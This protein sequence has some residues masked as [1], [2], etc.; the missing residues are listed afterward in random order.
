MRFYSPQVT[1]SLDGV[2]FEKSLEEFK[3]L[4]K[5]DQLR[6]SLIQG[7]SADKLIDFTHSNAKI[8]T[9]LRDPID[10]IISHYFYIKTYKGHFLHKKIIEDSISLKDYC[11]LNLSND[12]ENQYIVHFSKLP[13]SEIR[14]N[15]EAALALALTNI[16]KK[17]DLIGFQSNLTDF[18]TAF[19]EM[20]KLPKRN[21]NNNKV[22]T[23]S[24]RLKVEEL[25]EGTLNGIVKYNQLDILFYK[26]LVA[27][28]KNGVVK[29]HD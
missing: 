12:L 14:K 28:Q 9:I 20:M 8:L 1:Y 2:H 6:F 29:K 23:T 27:M 4:S 18:F 15:E 13:L 22:N 11:S 19:S 26:K 24:K 3:A 21:I 16:T 5:K 25:D 17:Y 10:R 7:H